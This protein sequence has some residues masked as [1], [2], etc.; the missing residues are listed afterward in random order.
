M[1]FAW[2]LA[3][4][5]VCWLFLRYAEP[6]HNSAAFG[7]RDCFGTVE[8]ALPNAQRLAAKRLGRPHRPRALLALGILQFAF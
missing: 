3:I 2:P 6:V 8:A 1:K 7:A 5:L 4:A